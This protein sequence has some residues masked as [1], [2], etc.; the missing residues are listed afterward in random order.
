ML[1]EQIPVKNLSKIYADLIPNRPRKELT[2]IKKWEAEMGRFLSEE[3]WERVFEI[4]HRTTIANKYQE[5]NYKIVMRWYRSPVTLK[6]INKGNTELCWRCKIEKGTTEHIWYG[7]PLVIGFWNEIFQ[8]Y[9][10]VLGVEITSSLEISLLSLIPKSIKTI[11]KDII[12]HMTSAART[13]IARNWRKTRSPTIADWVCEMNEIQYMEK[14]IREEGYI[15][16]QIPK[17]W[18]SWDEFRSSR[19]ILEYL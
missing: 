7:C 12:I 10:K 18:Q 11:K 19:E 2:S 14:Q 17:I 5:R 15:I 6:L 13:I 4:I 8:I 9:Y 16:N 1:S 3:E